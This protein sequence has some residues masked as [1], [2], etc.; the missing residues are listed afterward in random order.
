MTQIEETSPVPAPFHLGRR[1]SLIGLGTLVVFVLV[2]AG[3]GFAGYHAG[4][5]ERDTQARATQAAD[6]E[7]QYEL[8]LGDIT[9]GRYEVAQA[10]FEYIL[11]LDPQFRDA[12]QRLAQVRAALAVTPTPTPA[13][14][15][16][17]PTLPPPT[18]TLSHA[19][20]DLLAQ[21]Q[22]QYAAGDWA[23]VIATLGRL[24]AVDA[25][26]EAVKANG[27]L[28]VA[29]RNEGVA[30]IDGSD[31]ETGMFDLD[32]AE[33]IGPLD[34]DALNRRAW[35][36]LYLAAQSFWGLNWQQALIN[37]QELHLI[38]PYF[39]DTPTLLYEATVSYADQ[40]AHAGDFCGAAQHYT[41]AQDLK[42]DPKIAEA[43]VT[44]QASC[45]KTPPASAQS[46]GTPGTPAAKTETKATPTP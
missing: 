19:A 39:H 13:P 45:A 9:A 5:S 12:A 40:L 29:Y 23:G 26:Y 46:S 38:A 15:T 28:Y 24:H 25:S 21:A 11:Q 18:A 36:R 31:I 16:A 4:L 42:P 3:A 7:H 27:L 34:S 22:T 41:E 43:L 20:A 1:L 30:L 33:A 2:L 14:A 17:T 44:A 32:K 6:L 10:R 8:G 37:L 35:G